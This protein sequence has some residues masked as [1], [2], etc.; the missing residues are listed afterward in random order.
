MERRRITDAL[1]HIREWMVRLRAILPGVLCAE[2]WMWEVQKRP[3]DD[4]DTTR[5]IV[6]SR[7]VWC[8]NLLP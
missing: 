7:W 5:H 8:R 3:I 1:D 2:E 6:G 4:M